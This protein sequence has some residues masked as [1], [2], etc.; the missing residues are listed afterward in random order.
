VAESVA[1][2]NRDEPTER[3]RQLPSLLIIL[4]TNLFN[5]ER[6]EGCLCARDHMASSY[7][8]A[9]MILPQL[10]QARMEQM[11]WK[12]F[13]LTTTFLS[14]EG[15]PVARTSGGGCEAE[16]DLLH[17]VWTCAPCAEGWAEGTPEPVWQ[18]SG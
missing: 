10:E 16:K 4:S 15:D 8:L 13:S 1:G 2:G 5:E 17:G 6:Y 18:R 14:A 7:K 11:L 12:Y 9:S 3:L